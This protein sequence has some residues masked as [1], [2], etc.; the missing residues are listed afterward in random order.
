[1]MIRKNFGTVIV[2]KKKDDKEQLVRMEVKE[3]LE[4]N[5]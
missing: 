5:G 4:S 1:M 3:E 2:E